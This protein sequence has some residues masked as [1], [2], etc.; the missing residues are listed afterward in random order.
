VPGGWLEMRLERLRWLPALGH[1]P[2]PLAL[3]A[4]VISG[5]QQAQ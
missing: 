4:S 5:G 3:A 1:L 2:L